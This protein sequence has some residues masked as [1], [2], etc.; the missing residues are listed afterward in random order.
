MT[1]NNNRDIYCSITP[2]SMKRNYS[3][4]TTLNSFQPDWQYFESQIV[5]E[6]TNA[7]SDFNLE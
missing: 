1:N 7:I 6:L 3:M 4:G 2:Y 5:K